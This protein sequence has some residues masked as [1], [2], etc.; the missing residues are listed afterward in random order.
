[1][2]IDGGEHCQSCGQ[3]YATVYWLPDDVWA[4]ITPKPEQPGAG[5]LCVPCADARAR[6]AGL[7]LS[8]TAT[9]KTDRAK[10]PGV[11]RGQDDLFDRILVATVCVAVTAWVLINIFGPLA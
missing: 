10:L 4:R 5:L 9:A 1:M 7:T 8:W 11:L 2:T 3:A 6:V